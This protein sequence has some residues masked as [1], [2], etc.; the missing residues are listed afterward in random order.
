MVASMR[1]TSKKTARANSRFSHTV[2]TIPGRLLLIV[3]RLACVEVSNDAKV[4]IK[5][6]SFTQFNIYPEITLDITFRK[7]FVL[8][9]LSRQAVFQFLRLPQF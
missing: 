4:I 7:T 6:Y 3:R 5:C 2:R 8:P 1:N 9:L